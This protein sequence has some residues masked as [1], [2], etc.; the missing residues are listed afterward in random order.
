MDDDCFCSC[1]LLQLYSYDPKTWEIRS[2]CRGEDHDRPTWLDQHAG[3]G[4]WT[5]LPHLQETPVFPPQQSV[6]PT[7]YLQRTLPSQVGWRCLEEG[8][9]PIHQHQKLPPLTRFKL[10]HDIFRCKG[11]ILLETYSTLELQELWKRLPSFLNIVDDVTGRPDYSMF[12]LSLKDEWSKTKKFCHS[13][14]GFFFDFG[15]F[16]VFV[17]L[18]V[19]TP[20]PLF[21]PRP[22]VLTL[23][24]VGAK[25]NVQVDV[26]SLSRKAAP[27]LL[28][29]FSQ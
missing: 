24:L 3:P 17:L 23:P 5:P 1:R 2:D 19:L 27:F 7:R 26:C 15:F 10:T 13:I 18:T 12:N 21:R 25:F 28:T 22:S 8:R 29:K 14:A 4:R 16:L 11:M 9:R 20:F 6:L